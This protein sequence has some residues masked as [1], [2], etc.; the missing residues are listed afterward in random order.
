M[1]EGGR[2]FQWSCRAERVARRVQDGIVSGGLL[3]LFNPMFQPNDSDGIQT[4]APSNH[5]R[6]H[7]VRPTRF[8][9]GGWVPAAPVSV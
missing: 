7:Q 5:A 8:D 2:E 1:R 3:N 9:S 6:F 4:V